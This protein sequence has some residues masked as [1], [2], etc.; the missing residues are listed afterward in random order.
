MDEREGRVV[1]LCG[2]KSRTK[3][4]FAEECDVNT[5]MG[6]FRT[7]GMVTHVTAKNP[8]YEDFS[9]PM[10]YLDALSAV[11]KA[12]EVFDAMPARVRARVNND[13]AELISFVADPANADELVE[14]GLKEPVVPREGAAEPPQN[15]PNEPSLVV[16][17]E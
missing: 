5:I 16:G 12:Q 14:L 2:G 3:Q 4:S 10:Q 15:P 8:V 6:K 9:E 11:A 13:P 17:G 7:T 1:T